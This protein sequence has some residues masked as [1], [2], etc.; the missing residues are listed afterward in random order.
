MGHFKLIKLGETLLFQKS[1]DFIENKK[2]LENQEKIKK[3]KIKK[4]RKTKNKKYNIF[5]TIFLAR[6]EESYSRKKP[7]TSVIT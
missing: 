6:N 7:K 1:N 5:F 2:N 3:F 4:C